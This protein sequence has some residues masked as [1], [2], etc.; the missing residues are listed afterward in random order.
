MGNYTSIE[1]A[2]I[3]ECP[4]CFDDTFDP[5]K[6]NCG[7]N[8][9]KYCIQKY[10]YN[11]LINYY[12]INCPYCRNNL[13]I[14]DLNLVLK[15]WIFINYFP[16]EWKQINTIEL[17]KKHKISKFTKLDFNIQIP[18][19]RKIIIPQLSNN[20]PFFMISPEINDISEF[21][22]DDIIVLSKYFNNNK[23]KYSHDILQHYSCGINCYMEYK[24]KW[25]H[26][27][28]NNLNKIKNIIDYNINFYEQYKY[29]KYK[30]KLFIKDPNDIMTI[31]QLEGTMNK[32]II[33]IKEQK[34]KCLFKMYFY[35]DHNN[36]FMINELFAINY[37]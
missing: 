18:F 14:Y 37:Y 34:C 22:E 25:F 17:N 30:I 12:E 11:Q 36:T 1:Q 7:H 35:T 4:I 33:I 6:L 8:F 32:G 16:E 27:L 24:N 10:V 20:L 31:N 21:F 26:F 13:N 28:K 9:D 29:S 15:E 19:V 23:L 3:F 5:I 2:K